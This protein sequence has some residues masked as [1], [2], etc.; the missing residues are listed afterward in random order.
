ML[1][2]LLAGC[3]QEPPSSDPAPDPEQAKASILELAG[4]AWQ[5]DFIGEPEAGLTAIEDSRTI[6]NFSIVN[7]FGSG[8][9]NWYQG[10]YEASA[11][12]L[13]LNPPWVCL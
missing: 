12:S 9:C 7:Y 6:L 11:P 1:I 5:L 10:V 3:N 8:G 13:K 4:T 2:A